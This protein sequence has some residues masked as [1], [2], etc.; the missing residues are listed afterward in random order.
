[1]K[2]RLVDD[3][4]KI[5]DLEAENPVDAIEEVKG[6]LDAEE[7]DAEG[8]VLEI[9]SRSWEEFPGL[10]SLDDILADYAE[11]EDEEFADVEA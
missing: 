3:N 2:F 11:E 9:L 10:E 7:I 4:D 6:L 8:N 1:M 5:F